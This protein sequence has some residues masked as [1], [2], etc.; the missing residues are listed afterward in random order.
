MF[1]A[2]KAKHLPLIYFRLVLLIGFYP[3]IYIIIFY[4]KIVIY[5]YF[6]GVLWYLKYMKILAVTNIR[7]VQYSICILKASFIVKYHKYTK[8]KKNNLQKHNSLE[9]Y[10]FF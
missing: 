6:G 4:K 8:K 5:L 9:K 3:L 1:S 10:A 7:A 2:W